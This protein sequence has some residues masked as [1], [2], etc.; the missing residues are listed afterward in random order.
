MERRKLTKADIDK[1]RNI[2]GFP[3]AEDED[4]ITGNRYKSYHIRKNTN[5][6]FKQFVEESRIDN[7]EPQR[8]ISLVYDAYSKSLI[9]VSK[10]AALLNVPVNEVLDSALFV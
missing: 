3:I 5:P 2:E 9:S 4:M 8:F 7:E 10:A 1:V 6:F